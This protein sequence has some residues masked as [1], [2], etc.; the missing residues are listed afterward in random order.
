MSMSVQKS[1]VHKMAKLQDG[2]KRLCLVDDLKMLKIT[3]SNT[4]SRN[5]L[6]PEI[7]DH[8]NILTG[9]CQ[10]DELKTKDKAIH[11]EQRIAAMMGYRGGR[12]EGD[13][14][15]LDDEYEGLWR[16]VSTPYTASGLEISSRDL[17]ESYS[18]IDVVSSLMAY[19]V[20]ILTPDSAWSCV[21]QST[22]PTKGMRSI[23]S[24]VS[25]SLEDFLP[26]ILLLMVIIVA[27]IIVTVIWVVIFV[28]V[29]VGVVI[30]VAIIGVVVFVTDLC[31]AG[32]TFHTRD[33]SQYTHW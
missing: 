31:D 30:V 14:E 19:F 2:V 9:E 4:S 28:N 33:D 1:Q 22:L 7:N 17:I 25:I 32:F 15:K 3:M 5:K 29:I 11:I 27:V 16:L 10:K 20:A 12:L 13:E 21:M 26:S 24:T 6:N 23:I 8:Y 18:D